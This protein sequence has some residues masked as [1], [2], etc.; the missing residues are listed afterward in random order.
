MNTGGTRQ[1][2][3]S[4]QFIRFSG[5]IVPLILFFYGLMI[6]AGLIDNSRYAGILYLFVVTGLWLFVSLIQFI[7]PTKNNRLESACLI[8]QHA[9]IILYVLIISGF[10]LLIASLWLLLLLGAYLVADIRGAQYSAAASIMVALVDLA[11]HQSAGEYGAVLVGMISM[12]TLLTV[13]ASVAAMMRLKEVD[14]SSLQKVKIQEAMQRERTLAIINNIS[15]GILNLDKNGIIRTYNAASLNLLDTNDSLNGHHLDEVLPLKSL[16]GKK[17]N[18]FDKLKNT[19]RTTVRDDLLYYYDKQESIRLELT[20]SPIRT[21]FSRSKK[22]DVINGYIVIMRD[23]TKQ[24]SLEEERDEFIS[25]VSHELRTPITIAEGTI[26]NVRLMMER[27]QMKPGTLESSVETAHEQIIFLS[28][29]VNDLS[30]LS[31]AERG[32]SDEKE[33]IDVAEVMKSIYTN[34]ASEAKNKKLRLNL[35]LGTRLGSVYTSRLYLEELLQN[36]VTNSIK[37][38]KKGSV[39]LSAKRSKNMVTFSVQDTGIGINK[40]D[41]KKIFNK[42]YRSEDYRTRETGGTGLGLYVAAK[43]ANKIDTHIK[44]ESRLNHGSL[45]YFDLPIHQSKD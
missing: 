38:T 34:Y 20:F 8:A 15:D 3:R 41:Q 21:T 19:P 24:K 23:V 43:L 45:F 14:T 10:S 17:I 25:V 42:F 37:Y 9:L 5:L 28:K 35:D 11:M 27:G 40:A 32:V 16:S 31:R 26:S 22:T 36:F 39:T 6:H 13:G 4:E 1:S 44:L 2:K 29:M 30:T 33:V 7:T 18:I 12:L